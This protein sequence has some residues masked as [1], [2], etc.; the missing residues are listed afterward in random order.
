MQGGQPSKAGSDVDLILL[1][2]VHTY[3]LLHP[4]R[5]KITSDLCITMSPSQEVHRSEGSQKFRSD[6]QGSDPGSRRTGAS[7]YEESQVSCL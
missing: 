2:V 3:Q 6:A 5:S 1:P 4:P 7:L